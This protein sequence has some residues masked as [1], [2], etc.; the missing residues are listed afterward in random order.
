MNPEK[1]NKKYIV[2]LLESEDIIASAESVRQTL[3]GWLDAVQTPIKEREKR[4]RNISKDAF[5]YGDCENIGY[6]SATYHFMKYEY[7]PN[8]T[9]MSFEL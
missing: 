2:S 6:C 5:Y 7:D 1:P 3:Y 4:T 9:Q 8:Y